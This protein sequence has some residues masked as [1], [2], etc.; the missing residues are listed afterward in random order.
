MAILIK[1]IKKLVQVEDEIIPVKRGTQMATLKCIDNAFLLI[2]GG[3]ISNYGHMSQLMSDEKKYETIDAS[4]KMVFPSYCDS[5]T[6]IV[7]AGSREKEFVDKIRGFSYQEIAKR[8][9]GI[10]NSAR[11]LHETSQEKLY[12][13]ALARVKEMIS[14]G[15]G[16]VEIKSGYGLN[17]EDEIKM[18]RVIKRISE[19]TPIAVKSTFLGAHAI[20]ERYRENRKGYVDEIINEMIPIVAS[21]ELAE[22]IDV[23]C[24]KGFFSVEDS[25]RILNAGLK[26]GLRATVHANQM[27]ESGGV[28]VGIKY[29]AIS[30]AHLEFTGVKQYE[31]LANSETIATLLPGA[32]FFLEMDYPSARMMMDYD[33]PIALASNYNPGSCPCGDMKFISAL[34]C[35]KMKMTPEEVFNATTINGAYAMGLGETHGTITRG[36]CANIFIT[37]E[38][39]SYEFIPYAFSTPLIDTVILNGK[40]YE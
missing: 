39:P 22:Y 24:E 27:S 2:E 8:G 3:F 16:A 34:A 6:H 32:T 29:D 18:L 12:F 26:Y 31:R 28:E 4:G 35:L 1:N 13:Q 36:K 37:K 9:G 11:H 20:P 23:F 33:I 10:L 21:E 40:K 30:V 15:T 19:E 38:V 14:F 5:H 25:D 7:Y 17:P